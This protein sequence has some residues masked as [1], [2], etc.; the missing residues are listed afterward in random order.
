MRK[1][2][3]NNQLRTDMKSIIIIIIINSD[4]TLQQRK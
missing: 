3:V 2:K 4:I 1:A